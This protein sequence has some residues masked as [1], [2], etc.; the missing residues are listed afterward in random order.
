MTQFLRL[1]NPND[2]NILMPKCELY[3]DVKGKWRW[4]LVSKNG[5]IQDHSDGGFEDKEECKKNGKEVG[6]CTSYKRV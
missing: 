3:K 6:N 4:R 5:D 1:H 2:R